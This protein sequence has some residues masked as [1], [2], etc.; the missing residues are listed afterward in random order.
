MLSDY[1][2]SDDD[3]KEAWGEDLF[4]IN[5]EA[6]STVKAAQSAEKFYGN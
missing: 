6:G 5:Q 4:K 1:G 2:V 3:M